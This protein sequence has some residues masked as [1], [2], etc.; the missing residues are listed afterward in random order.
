[1][2]GKAAIHDVL[3]HVFL[4]EDDASMRATL[5][6]LLEF[7]GYRVYP[8]ASAIEFLKIP[9]HVAPAVV[10]TDMRMPDMTGVELQAELIKRGREVPIIFISAESTVA[11]SITAMKQGAIEFLVKPFERDALL[12]AVI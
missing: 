4:I 12:D 9:L 5:T 7:L 2:T 10:I 6:S 1:M 8:F 3:K 11:Q